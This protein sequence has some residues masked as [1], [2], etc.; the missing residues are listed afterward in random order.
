[1]VNQK[2]LCIEGK[3]RLDIIRAAFSAGNSGSHIA[4]SLSVAEI[5]LA[6][7]SHLDSAKDTLIL[8]KGHG[9]LGCYSAM[10]QLGIITDEQFASFEENGG[11]FPGQPSRSRKN[12]I[13]FSS[14]SLGMG[15]SYGL[16]IAIGAKP[17]DGKAFVILGDGELNEGSN[18]EAAALASRYQA[19][20]LIAV[21][22]NNGMQS[23]GRCQ[24]IMGQQLRQIWEAHGWHI[25]MCDGHSITQL[26]EKLNCDHRG[27][28]L[29]IIAQTT[30]GKGISFMENNNA[31]HHAVLRERDF[32]SAKEEI[33][34]TYGVY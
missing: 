21:V 14:G 10:H 28:P 32:L 1:M 2:A 27:K 4:P 25:Q 9:A 11:D 19:E 29:V 34:Q 26:T 8:S 22:D 18:W 13:A 30:K 20:N 7:L 17:V 23:D 12:H 15:L 31:W 3:V 33:E 16:G 24:D 5:C 6:V